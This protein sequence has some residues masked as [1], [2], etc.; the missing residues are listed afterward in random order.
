[1]SDEDGSGELLE[2]TLDEIVS[3][4]EA[5]KQKMSVRGE[6]RVRAG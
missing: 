3:G 2:S 6:R 5:E 4:L 1:M